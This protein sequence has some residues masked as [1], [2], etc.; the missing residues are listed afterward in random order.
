MRITES[1]IDVAVRK[2]TEA[3]LFSRHCTSSEMQA[4]REIVR[5]I[6][7]AVAAADTTDAAM[8]EQRSAEPRRDAAH[9]AHGRAAHER[10]AGQPH[11]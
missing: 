7:D 2:A 11:R 10:R 1:I 6:L 3:G 9:S 5:S 4:N 8:P